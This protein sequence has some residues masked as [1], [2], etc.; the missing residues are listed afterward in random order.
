[1]GWRRWAFPFVVVGMNSIAM[2]CMAQLL[3]GWVAGSFKT[4]FGPGVF[5]GWYA[6]IVESVVVLGV[7]WLAC[8]W[9]YWRKVFIRI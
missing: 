9:M 7:L 8:L 1:V 2:Y 3:K 4:H 6:P 5:G